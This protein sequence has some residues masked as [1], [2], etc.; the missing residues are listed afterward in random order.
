MLANT[1][2]PTQREEMNKL[3]LS[4]VAAISLMAAACGSVAPEAGQEAVLIQK[5]WIFG[6]GGVYKTPVTS[7]RT[8]VALSTDFKM[9]EMKPMQAHVQFDDLMSKDGV[10]LDFDAVIRLQ[11]TDSVKLIRDYGEGWYATNVEA[12]FR[13]R[14]RQSVRKYGMNETA[15]DTT[16]I[17]K[18]DQEVTRAMEL[19]IKQ[20]GIPIKL[21]AVTVGKANPPDA[22]RTQRAVSAAE[23]QR[24]NTE[25]KTR[26]AEIARKQAQIAKADADNAYRTEMNLSPAQFIELERIK[27]MRAACAGEGRNCTFIAGDAPVLVGAK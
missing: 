26:Q 13:N 17:E 24:L 25:E 15:I 6:H 23:E 8:F 2:T 4:A 16:A 1:H 18:I 20:T 27:M 11:V 12:E 19:Y 7:G 9:V 3:K 22:V 14:V 10:P 21:L 5:P